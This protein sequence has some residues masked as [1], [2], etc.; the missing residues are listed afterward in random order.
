MAMN[1]SHCL[2]S[3]TRFIIVVY[4]NAPTTTMV[5]TYPYPSC[6]DGWWGCRTGGALCWR[7]YGL[8]PIG[9]TGGP[10]EPTGPLGCFPW[11][12]EERG[13]GGWCWHR[14]CHFLT[15]CSRNRQRLLTPRMSDVAAHHRQTKHGGGDGDHQNKHNEVYSYAY[16]I[17]MFQLSRHTNTFVEKIAKKEQRNH[18]TVIRVASKQEI[19]VQ[20]KPQL[21]GSRAPFQWLPWLQHTPTYTIADLSRVPWKPYSVKTYERW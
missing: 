3:G 21:C 7:R 4:R 2:I 1:Q 19:T 16:A 8:T 10:P 5:Q 6:D 13:V 20:T 12:A 18:L 14:W 9:G 11:W 17:C 15:K